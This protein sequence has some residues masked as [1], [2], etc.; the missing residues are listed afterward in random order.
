MFRVVVDLGDRLPQLEP[1]PVE[2]LAEAEEEEAVFVLSQMHVDNTQ[3]EVAID[4]HGEPIGL[5]ELLRYPKNHGTLEP[6]GWMGSE[7]VEE[8]KL[9]SPLNLIRPPPLAS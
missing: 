7:A 8:E 5:P 2:W 6:I 1:C 9:Q 4:R 3:W